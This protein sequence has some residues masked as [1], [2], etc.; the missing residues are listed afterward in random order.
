MSQWYECTRDERDE[1]TTPCL[2]CFFV[3][4]HVGDVMRVAEPDGGPIPDEPDDRD[5]FDQAMQAIGH[6]HAAAAAT[7]DTT[8]ERVLLAI[9]E[10][11]DFAIRA[12]ERSMS[13]QPPLK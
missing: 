8:Y 1:R 12:A 6:L 2:S 3:E 7:N 9:D 13:R 5:P 10:C 11:A 4:H